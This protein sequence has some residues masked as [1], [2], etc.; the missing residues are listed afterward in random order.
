MSLQKNQQGAP[1]HNQDQFTQKIQFCLLENQ[2]DEWQETRSLS[3]VIVFL[4]FKPIF[5][6]NQKLFCEDFINPLFNKKNGQNLKKN[7]NKKNHLLFSQ[8]K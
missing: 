4:T 7:Y 3:V 6:K 8:P 2:I 1:Y 5:P